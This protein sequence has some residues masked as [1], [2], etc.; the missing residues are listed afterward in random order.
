M[1]PRY[2]LLGATRITVGFST[3]CNT[4]DGG[5]CF[6]WQLSQPVGVGPS[7]RGPQQVYKLQ[8]TRT[9]K[10]RHGLPACRGKACL[11]YS[12]HRPQSHGSYQHWVCPFLPE[13][14]RHEN[15]LKLLFLFI[16]ILFAKF[17]KS[18]HLAPAATGVAWLYPVR[19]GFTYWQMILVCG[20]GEGN[21]LKLLPPVIPPFAL[22]LMWRALGS[23]LIILRPQSQSNTIPD[24]GSSWRGRLRFW[25]FDY[26][27]MVCFSFRLS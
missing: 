1:T 24:C 15:D 20:F 14:A 9:S 11:G 4:S 21:S 23:N 18:W 3:V 26:Y 10:V 16:F 25:E 27:R 19:F 5:H 8:K 6:D 13:R 7:W 17:L 2:L 22:D 12:F